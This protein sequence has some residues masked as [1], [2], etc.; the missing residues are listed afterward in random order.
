GPFLSGEGPFRRTA[1]ALATSVCRSHGGTPPP[2][3]G[4]G[5]DHPELN[6]ATLMRTPFIAGNWK[7]FTTAAV[8]RQLATAIVAGLAGDRRVQVAVCPPFPYL[9]DVAEVLRGS[10]VALGAQNLYPEKEGAFT[11][12]VSP[13]MLV[14]VGCQFV[15]VGHS[16]RRHQLGESDA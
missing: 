2:G 5:Q 4:G 9:R 11:G 16:E 6:R 10:H 13:A 8:A 15:I 12:E 3:G 1:S 14:D 7:M